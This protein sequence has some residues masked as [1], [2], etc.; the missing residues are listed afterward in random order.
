[1]PTVAD[2]LHAHAPT[3][4]LTVID[5][6]V[7]A[8]SGNVAHARTLLDWHVRACG[9]CAPRHAW[10]SALGDVMPGRAPSSSPSCTATTEGG[11]ASGDVR[12]NKY[13]DAT[14]LLRGV[15]LD[16]VVDPSLTAARLGAALPLGYD[17]ARAFPSALEPEAVRRACAHL[18]HLAASY[19]A[20]L[21]ADALEALVRRAPS[22]RAA[23]T[24][25]LAE[26]AALNAVAGLRPNA[27]SAVEPVRGAPWTVATAGGTYRWP[28]VPTLADAIF[29]ATR[30]WAWVKSPP[31]TTTTTTTT[32]SL[33]AASTPQRRPQAA[34][35]TATAT[36]P[37]AILPPPAWIA[38]R[39]PRPAPALARWTMRERLLAHAPDAEHVTA[40]QR[41]AYLAALAAATPATY[42]DDDD[43]DDDDDI[44]GSRPRQPVRVP[45]YARRPRV[46]AAAPVAPALVNAALDDDSACAR[47]RPS[48]GE[49]ER[50]TV[51]LARV[52]QECE[53]DGAR[54]LAALGAYTEAD[55]AELASLWAPLVEA[56][57]A[58]AAAE[59]A[60]A[61]RRRTY[62]TTAAAP[63]AN[64]GSAPE[65]VLAS[66]RAALADVTVGSTPL[67]PRLVTILKRGKYARALPYRARPAP[68]APPPSTSPPPTPPPTP[69]PS[70]KRPRA[71]SIPPR[72][73]VRNASR[74]T[75]PLATSATW[76]RV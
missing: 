75:S 49:L 13:E 59:A 72:P 25:A 3:A 51:R 44:F 7:A 60:F 76:A 45:T 17:H 52:R 62:T 57:A 27:R 63:L 23:P 47:V 6:V 28:P 9:A 12:A 29:Y 22:V 36:A 71:A 56:N 50:S 46:A 19:D 24:T 65:R 5:D 54:S 33:I 10:R 43:D 14:L 21:D 30:P 39:W 16:A 55:R 2:Y 48:L 53:R 37:L 18:G 58:S 31:T 69:P 68:P 8:A 73:L 4:S 32:S 42:D 66:A 61:I 74:S 15:A 35:A 20:L 38:T 41:R 40:R 34:A 64:V 26:M 70:H 1:M 11:L 67:S